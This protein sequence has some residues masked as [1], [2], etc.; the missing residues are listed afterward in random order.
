MSLRRLEVGT[1]GK[2]VEL[3]LESTLSPTLP[4]LCAVVGAGFMWL[5]T[6]ER[7]TAKNIVWLAWALG[8]FFFVL[9][10]LLAHR[11]LTQRRYPY[12]ALIGARTFTWCRAKG[13]PGKQWQSELRRFDRTL[14]Q[15]TRYARNL[16]VET[17]GRV[18]L[19]FGGAWQLAPQDER[20][21]V[22]VLER[23]MH[24]CREGADSRDEIGCA[25]AYLDERAAG[26]DLLGIALERAKK[27]RVYWALADRADL[28]A[29]LAQGLVAYA[30]ER[31]HRTL[32]ETTGDSANLRPLRGVDRG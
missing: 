22:E 16:A 17:E 3:P 10:G 2:D 32:A 4:I 23:R 19:L 18:V 8:L 21:F 11:L 5:G 29:A 15:T 6:T 27:A 26:R 13:A 9:S 28:E 1:Y 25:E 12:V 31:A 20:R 30:P 14:V 24:L 7:A